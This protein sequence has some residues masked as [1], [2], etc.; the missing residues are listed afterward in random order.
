MTKQINVL[1]VM[2]RAVTDELPLMSTVDMKEAR[3]AVAE[4]MEAMSKIS[5]SD[6]S[7]DG[8]YYTNRSNIGIAKKAISRVRGAA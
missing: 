5:K 4:L 6:P 8:C 1:A 3:A 7:E 2:D